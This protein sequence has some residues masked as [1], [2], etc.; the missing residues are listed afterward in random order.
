MTMD[1]DLFE[2]I[3]DCCLEESGA[4]LKRGYLIGW[5]NG[6]CDV[7]ARGGLVTRPR[8]I[9]NLESIEPELKGMRKHY[10]SRVFF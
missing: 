10:F 1:E 4:E 2:Y 3:C 6:V 7:C 5:D 8:F 9:E